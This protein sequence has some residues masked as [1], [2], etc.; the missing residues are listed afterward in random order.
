MDKSLIVL[1]TLVMAA[2]AGP[3][4]DLYRPDQAQ[5][6]FRVFN[7]EDLG[8]LKPQ[9]PPVD[10]DFSAIMLDL[11]P[12]FTGV[13]KKFG[14]SKGAQLSPTDMVSVFFPIVRKAFEA[15]AK[16]EGRTLKKEEERAISL[17]ETATTLSTRVIEGLSVN[18]SPTDIIYD[19]MSVTRPIMEANAASED[20]K[21][22]QD[23]NQQISLL[24]GSI[25][26]TIK[27][28]ED[29]TKDNSTT[30]IIASN[31][32]LAQDIMELQA[33]AENRHLSWEEQKSLNQVASAIQTGNEIMNDFSGFGSNV[34]EMVPT[35]MRLT[36]FLYDQ[37]ALNESRVVSWEEEKELR[38][39]K[40]TLTNSLGFI[41][42][43]ITN[44]ASED[45]L[46]KFMTT[47]RKMFEQEALI[48]GRSS[49]DSDLEKNLKITER[50]LNLALSVMNMGEGIP[51]SF[52]SQPSLNVQSII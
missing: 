39:T 28:M 27:T 49:L 19:V 17:T 24:E 40:S 51:N 18:S 20:R 26:S 32:R 35:F 33:K 47:T 50:A 3:A 29:M 45:S 11:L 43:I 13:L 23:E 2:V 42:E 4:V 21:L 38:F 12:E 31:I 10:D 22:T 52:S 8:V 37:R 16:S 15:K 7:F 41:Q 6:V 34:A 36:R 46:K 5:E 48:K 1:C 44:S 25:A 9:P 30:G 14:G